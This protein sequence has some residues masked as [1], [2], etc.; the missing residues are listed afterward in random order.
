[1][2]VLNPARDMFGTPDKVHY[3]RPTSK[4]R[5]EIEF[6]VEVPLQPGNNLISISARHDEEVVEHERLWVLSTPG[7]DETR[8]AEAEAKAGK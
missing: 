6:E 8:A 4:S 2:Q 1:M 5:G 7:L 3:A